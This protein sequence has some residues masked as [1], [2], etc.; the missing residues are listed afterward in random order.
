MVMG[1][2]IKRNMLH[3]AVTDTELAIIQQKMNRLGVRNLSA[4][5]RA[6]VLNG[7]ILK[8]DLT[9][10]RKLTR[11]LSNMSNNI[12][13]IAK[14]MNANGNI[15]ETELDEIQQNQKELWNMMNNILTGLDETTTGGD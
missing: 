14:R 13:Q 11:L 5:L 12:N 3:F 2:E 8:L 9:E 1:K 10:I 7:F 15:Y 4:F 6:M